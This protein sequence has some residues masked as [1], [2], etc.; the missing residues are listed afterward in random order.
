VD[1]VHPYF[2]EAL[3][4]AR[5]RDLEAALARPHRVAVRRAGRTRRRPRVALGMGLI[6]LGLRL[7]DNG[8]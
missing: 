7:V 8:C 2:S 5:R 6:G 1:D 4:A 3:I